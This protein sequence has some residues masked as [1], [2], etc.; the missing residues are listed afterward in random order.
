MK[1]KLKSTLS[2]EA[3]PEIGGTINYPSEAMMTWIKDA[4]V[5]RE[6]K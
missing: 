4:L 1:L 2:L 6:G 3:M 5:K